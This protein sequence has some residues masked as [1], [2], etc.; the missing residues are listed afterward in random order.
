MKL[1]CKKSY[2]THN[3]DAIPRIKEGEY[4]E[5]L[6]QYTKPTGIFPGGRYWLFKVPNRDGSIG[7][8]HF[9]IDEYF[10]TPEEV[11]ENKINNILEI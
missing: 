7:S 3:L 11:R 6:K 5:V 8:G 9:L 10:V 2:F 1:K 4:Y